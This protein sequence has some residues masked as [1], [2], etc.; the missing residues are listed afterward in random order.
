M[1]QNAIVQRILKKAGKENLIEELT[2]ALAPSEINTLLLALAAKQTGRITPPGLLAQYASNRFVRPSGLDPVALK[3]R[4]LSMLEAAEDHGFTPVSLSPA[5]LLGSCSA[6]AKVDQNNVVSACRGV[7]LLSDATNMLALYLAK[8]IKSG[9]ASQKSPI[10]LS[11]AS[12]VT[13]A[14][15]YKSSS[16][17]AHFTLFSLVSGGRDIGSY[18][19]EKDAL[20][21]QIGYY[22]AYFEGLLG[23]K[24][25]ITLNPRKGYADMEGFVSRVSGYLRESF[26]QTLIEIDRKPAESEYYIGVNYKV[27]VNDLE[28]ADGGFVDWTQAMLRDRKQRLLISGTG[29]DRQ[30][31]L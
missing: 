9:G 16:L 8:K 13:R 19:F 27:R 30:L 24:I 26:P 10:H 20:T 15:Y 14:Q 1:R 4:E 11:A 7:E 3:R 18:G 25:I 31:T 17:S 5:G 22:I 21:R 29:I 6:V 2:T 12:Q 28:I 23:M